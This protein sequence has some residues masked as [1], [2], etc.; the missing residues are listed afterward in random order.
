MQH[1]EF[2][3]AMKIGRR[4]LVVDRDVV[5]YID[6]LLVERAQA[7]LQNVKRREQLLQAEEKLR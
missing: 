4:S 2:P 7:F 3:P 6:G 1:G 5:D